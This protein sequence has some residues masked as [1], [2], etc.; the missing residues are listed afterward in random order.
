MYHLLNIKK[1]PPRLNQKLIIE[2]LQV[3]QKMTIKAVQITQIKIF[4]DRQQSNH[5]R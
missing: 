3:T 4:I 2:T 5:K 1:C